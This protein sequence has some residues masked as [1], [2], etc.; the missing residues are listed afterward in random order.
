VLGL[1][2][3]GYT[4]K[5]IASKLVIAEVTAK[6]HVRNILR[7]LRLRSRTEAAVFATKIELEG[8]KAELADRRDSAIASRGS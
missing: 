1:L 5:E 8:A 4:N 2:G 7:K 3:L 6:V